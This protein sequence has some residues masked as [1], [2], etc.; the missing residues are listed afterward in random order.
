MSDDDKKRRLKNHQE[1]LAD[2]LR[3]Y[4]RFGVPPPPNPELIQ[5]ICDNSLC[6]KL[7]GTIKESDRL[8][9]TCRGV[10]DILLDRC[11]PAR[12]RT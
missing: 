3:Q 6:T 11:L 9:P 7:F 4:R 8:C 1:Q 12:D 5:R 10:T 2:Q